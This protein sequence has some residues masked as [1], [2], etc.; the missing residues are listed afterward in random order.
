MHVGDKLGMAAIGDLLR[1]KNKVIINAFPEGQEIA[2]TDH[3]TAT[4]YH[5]GKRTSELH[6][7]D[8][9]V[10]GGC[11]EIKLKN[12]RSTTRVSPRKFMINSVLRMHKALRMHAAA[13]PDSPASKL[14]HEVLETLTEIYAVLDLCGKVCVRSL[15][16]AR[17]LSPLA[18]T[19][20]RALAARLHA[21]ARSRRSLARCLHARARS[22]C[23]WL[24]PPRDSLLVATATTRGGGRSLARSLAR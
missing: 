9:M 3:E 22:R 19:R 15:A 18:C 17:A 6:K 4:Y 2:A 13:H 11:A 5:Y 20:A 8:R 10:P 21:R 24:P 12:D 14:T 23:G 1:S 7:F 16:R